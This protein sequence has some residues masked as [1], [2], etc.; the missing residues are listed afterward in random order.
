MLAA[1]K[2]SAVTSPDGTLA[3]SATVVVTGHCSPLLTCPLAAKEMHDLSEKCDD[4][5]FFQKG[6]TEF[7]P[8]AEQ[9]A[10]A[11]TAAEM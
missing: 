8:T 7:T 2:I 9:R 10:T 4:G 3:V 11:G 1:T 6:P 5:A